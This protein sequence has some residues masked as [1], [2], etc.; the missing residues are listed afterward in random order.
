M[1]TIRSIP[2][3]S[4]IAGP[5][6][7]LLQID[8]LQRDELLRRLYETPALERTARK[9]AALRSAEAPRMLVCNL[10]SSPEMPFFGL[11]SSA[12]CAFVEGTIAAA[13][14]SES[15]A[16]ICVNESD[17]VITASL[18]DAIMKI[19]QANDV[20]VQTLPDRLACLQENA[21]RTA[22]QGRSPVTKAR[23][24][25]DLSC[26]NGN[27]AVLDAQ[28]VL[29]LYHWLNHTLPDTK[30]PRV[31]RIDGD[32]CAPGIAQVDDGTTF[33]RMLAMAGGVRDGLP[34]KYL[35]FG[36]P[37]G[38]LI[39]PDQ[40]D[41]TMKEISP[42]EP[43]ERYFDVLRVYD[44]SHCIV[45]TL[46]K[47][48]DILRRESCGRCVFCREGCKQMHAIL[49]DIA[50]AK[51]TL[52]D[53]GLLELLSDAAVDGALCDF[54]RGAGRVMR[55]ALGTFR[56][57]IEA[58]LNRRCHASLCKGFITYHILPRACNGCGVCVEVCR[59]KAIAGDTGEIHVIDGFDCNKCGECLTA[60]PENGI[61]RAGA[62]KPRTPKEPIP[63]GTWKGR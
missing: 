30:E 58:H 6:T 54:G 23:R 43:G 8:D 13:R 48:M 18:A 17:P 14:A 35:Q 39:T 28:E 10:W 25:N 5:G 32:V 31:I 22:L 52:A 56:P 57:E 47:T 9:I 1:E 26:G 11:D 20:K 44:D 15:E 61:V 50:A 60:C 33:R 38:Y 51:G 24:D 3:L 27:A 59:Q 4:K 46:R 63:V 12:A 16:L 37:S 36:Y 19:P 7:A 40:L 34:L 55:G 62:V 45:D 42:Q 29:I 41:S 49:E 21:L 2:L 53:P